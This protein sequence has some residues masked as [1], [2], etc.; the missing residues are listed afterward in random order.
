MA[1]RNAKSGT[2]NAKCRQI[3]KLTKKQLGFAIG[4]NILGQLA[5]IASG[6]RQILE[7]GTDPAT[8]QPLRCAPEDIKRSFSL[9]QLTAVE[10]F[11]TTFAVD[12]RDARPDS[13]TASP[14]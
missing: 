6:I 13:P 1:S 12:E 3:A 14:K 4:Q 9:E 5:T 11:Y 8:K 7:K 10:D 2:R